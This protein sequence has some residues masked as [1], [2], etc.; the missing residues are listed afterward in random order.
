M[1]NKMKI[2]PERIENK[3]LIRT[4]LIFT[5]NERKARTLIMMD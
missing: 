5:E 4:V 3:T 1:Q 2:R